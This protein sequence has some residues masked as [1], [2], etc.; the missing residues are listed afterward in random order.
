MIIGTDSSIPMVSPPHKNPSCGS[1]SDEA[2]EDQ[3][4]PLQ[5]AEANHH[6]QNRKQHDS[7]D[8]RLVKLAGM[9]RQ[10]SAIGK[11]HRPGHAGVR[12]PA[13]QLA[14]DEVGEP[15]EKQPDRADPG[16]DIAER[17]DRK[18]VLAAEQYHRGHAAQKAAMER[19]AALPQLKNLS[20]ML[21]EERE[22][23]EQH[24]AGAAAEDDADRDP[25]DEIVELRQRDRRR[26][27]P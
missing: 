25:Q 21:D 8:R 11:H 4:R 2:A 3:A 20:G 7:L 15:P 24:V 19:H 5:G 12:R 27:A 17:Q 10:R 13:P 1:G 14:V 9:A 6:G 26:P 22:I 18:I 16:G 23:V